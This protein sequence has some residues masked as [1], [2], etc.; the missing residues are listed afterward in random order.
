MEHK[1]PSMRNIFNIRGR[2]LDC[3]YI[4]LRN[5][6]GLIHEFLLVGGGELS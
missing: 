5:N 3:P 1:I 6:Q 2:T 4:V